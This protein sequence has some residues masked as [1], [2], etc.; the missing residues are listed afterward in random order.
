M[1]IVTTGKQTK[2]KKEKEYKKD[3]GYIANIFK[4]FK[5]YVLHRFIIVV[6]V[7][8]AECVVI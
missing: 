8:V 6:E 1:F 7:I 3:T 2:L 4:K 5:L